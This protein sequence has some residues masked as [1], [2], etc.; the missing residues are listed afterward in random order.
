MAEVISS[1]SV[2]AHQYEIAAEI[3]ELIDTEYP[4]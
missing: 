2:L 1:V 4:F 3:A